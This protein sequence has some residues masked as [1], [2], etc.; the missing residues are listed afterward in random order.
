MNAIALDL[1]NL[2][3]EDTRVPQKNT[4][5]EKLA[6]EPNVCTINEQEKDQEIM[7]GTQN[8]R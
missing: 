3:L 1:V 8:S 2:L 5:S 6:E 4:H 7:Y